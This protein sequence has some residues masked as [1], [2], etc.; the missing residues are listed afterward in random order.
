MGKSRVFFKKV[1]DTYLYTVERSSRH[2]IYDFNPRGE[3]EAGSKFG[4]LSLDGILKTCIKIGWDH[5]GKNMDREEK[6]T[7]QY[8]EPHVVTQEQAKETEIMLVR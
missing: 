5:L 2:W 3:I 6:W 8:L 1:G 7:V 4:K